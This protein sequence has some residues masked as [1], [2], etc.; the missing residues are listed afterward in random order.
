MTNIE[1]IRSEMCDCEYDK[2]QLFDYI[3]CLETSI[4]TL[5]KENTRLIQRTAQFERMK[6]QLRKIRSNGKK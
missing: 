3:D 1:K 4:K 5:V 6:E 2:R